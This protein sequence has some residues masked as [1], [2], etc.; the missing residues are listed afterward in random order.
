MYL[1]LRTIY[2]KNFCEDP[3]TGIAKYQCMKVQNMSITNTASMC[4]LLFQILNTTINNT[5]FTLQTDSVKLAAE[6]FRQK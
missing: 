6:D 3:E 5:S 4:V 2:I 1:S